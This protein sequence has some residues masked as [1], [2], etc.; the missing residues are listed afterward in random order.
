M[1]KKI[2]LDAGHG[3]RTLGK[4]TPDG[5]KEWVL[6]DKV[7]DKVVALL[8]NYDVEFVFPDNDEGNTDESL[9]Y[10]KNMYLK[11]DVDA[12]VSIHHNAFRGTWG[13]ATGVEVWVDKNPTTQD[14]QLANCI[15]GKMISYIG[16]QG[17]GIK[18]ENW[19]IINQNKI[20][21]VLTE[22]GFMDGNN[23]YKV[24][25]SDKGQTAYAKAIAEGLIEFL[26]LKKRSTENNDTSSFTVK[27][28]IGNL[29]IRKGP[30]TNYLK[31]GLVT[32]KGVFTIVEV[33][34]GSG[35]KTGWGKLKSGTGWIS[36]YY[37]TRI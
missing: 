8:K 2:A 20:P 24:I 31:T 12:V 6:N 4:Q 11:E 15:Y 1:A 9:A 18:K 29:N 3:L 17:R 21:A 28:D 35:S 10:R 37:T 33:K 14:I 34:P 27:V 19:Y 5:I 7:R 23:D 16:L 26:Q 30:G 13:N 25:T 32:G 36:L 22:G